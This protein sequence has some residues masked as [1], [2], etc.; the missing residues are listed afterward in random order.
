MNNKN[1][2]VL[3]NHRVMCAEFAFLHSTTEWSQNYWKNVFNK[4]YEKL[5]KNQ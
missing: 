2:P 4:L 5:L 1:E 3:L